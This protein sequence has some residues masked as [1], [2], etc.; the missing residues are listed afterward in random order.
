MMKFT[1]I[2]TSRVAFLALSFIAGLIFNG[3][4]LPG[5]VFGLTSTVG[6]REAIATCVGGGSVLVGTAIVGISSDPR[7]AGAVDNSNKQPEEFVS[8]GQQ[9]PPPDGSEPF[10]TLDN[11]VKV[12][13]IK[14]GQGDSVVKQNSRV[15]IQLNGRLLNLN[16]VMFYSTKNNN[17]GK[18]TST[19]LFFVLCRG[20]LDC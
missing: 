2:S 9:A 1:N 6:R 10:V 5:T 11:G 16:G 13:D 15:D 19:N 8:V 3:D 12:K 14:I 7:P 17:P 4:S 18:I 20:L